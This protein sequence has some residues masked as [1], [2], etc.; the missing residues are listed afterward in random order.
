MEPLP[1]SQDQH[2]WKKDMDAA[3]SSGTVGDASAV[4]L[5][6]WSA[7]LS[8]THKDINLNFGDDAAKII[9]SLA[10]GH[11]QSA[12][13]IKDLEETIER[14][15][16]TSDKTQR[17]I[18]ILTVI[19]VFLAFI[20]AVAAF[21]TIRDSMSKEFKIHQDTVKNNVDADDKKQQPLQPRE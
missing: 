20:Q 4:D 10:I 2:Q 21:M 18:T 3:F 14:L 13:A 11:V 17:K 1:G 5:Q 15:N 6:R 7:M 9:R 19:A 12:R 16:G 8:S